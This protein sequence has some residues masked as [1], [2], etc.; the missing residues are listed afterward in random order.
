MYF[1]SNFRFLREVKWLIC[2]L[3][4]GASPARRYQ[5]PTSSRHV[6]NKCLLNE[7][8]L[9]T[10]CE[11]RSPLCVYMPCPRAILAPAI[12]LESAKR[13]TA[14]YFRRGKRDRRGNKTERKGNASS[15]LQVV[16]KERALGF[17]KNKLVKILLFA[18]ALQNIVTCA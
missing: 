18:L 16:E 6:L 1:P 9:C 15:C 13:V 10:P 8:R 11:F 2:I 4:T 14:V 12:S 17:Y 7:S 3:C 5:R